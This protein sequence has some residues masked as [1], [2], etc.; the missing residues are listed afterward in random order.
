MPEDKANQHL[1]STLTLLLLGVQTWKAVVFLI[2][3]LLTKTAF[4]AEAGWNAAALD[5]TGAL[6]KEAAIAAILLLARSLDDLC[7]KA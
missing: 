1:A 6:T 3:P 2:E 7:E 5:A 4:L